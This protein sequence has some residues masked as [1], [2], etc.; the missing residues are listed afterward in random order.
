MRKTE[1]NYHGFKWSFQFFKFLYK[2]S[3]R[4]LFFRPF[5][6]TELVTNRLLWTM[7]FND[8][9]KR[10]TKAISP[11]KGIFFSGKIWLSTFLSSFFDPTF[12]KKNFSTEIRENYEI[13]TKPNCLLLFNKPLPL[14]VPVCTV[15][16]TSMVGHQIGWRNFSGLSSS[17]G[18]PRGQRPLVRQLRDNIRLG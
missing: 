3:S 7:K 18:G 6:E 12:Q 8:R 5:R 1:S 16:S 10:W 14:C 4:I 17:N 11:T 2:F 15:A 13:E 9:Q